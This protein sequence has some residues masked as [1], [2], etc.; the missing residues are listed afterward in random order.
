MFEGH[1]PYL[2]ALSVVIAILGGF[3]GF[4]LAARI[5][6]TPGVS[7]RVLLAGGGP[8]S[9][10]G[11]HGRHVGGLAGNAA[12]RRSSQWASG[13]CFSSAGWGRRSRPIPSIWCCPP[14]SRF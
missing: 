11:R 9:P 14:S 10:R 3:T 1:D 4:G 8:G 2:V 7:R 5:R 6:G 12:P 13:P